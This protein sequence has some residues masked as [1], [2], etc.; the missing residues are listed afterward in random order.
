MD[1]LQLLKEDHQKVRGL[2]NEFRSAAEADDAKKMEDLKESIFTELDTHTAI[3]ERVFYPA[4][5]RAGGGKLDDLTD[6]S[7]EEH[8][9]V[10]LLIEEVRSLSSSDNQFKAKMKVMME[11]VEHHASEEENKMFPKVRDLMDAQQLE[12]LGVELEEEKSKVKSESTSRDELYQAAKEQ[13]VE[14]RSSMDK[15]ELAQAVSD[16]Q[17]QI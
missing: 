8:H 6:E 3:E 17:Q 4:V 14:G 5:R 7:K 1:A 15:E 16:E 9:V 2:F 10:D 11:N 13:G 12:Q